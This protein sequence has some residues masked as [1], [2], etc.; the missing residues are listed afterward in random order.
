MIDDKAF[1]AA[2]SQESYG[3]TEA[4][5]KIS[6]SGEW[7]LNYCENVFDGVDEIMMETFIAQFLAWALSQLSYSCSFIEV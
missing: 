1:C 7:A 6:A 3:G 5:Y 4:L 2:L